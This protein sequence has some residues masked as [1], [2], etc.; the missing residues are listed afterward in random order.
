MNE[1]RQVAL[2]N[3]ELTLLIEALDA[4]CARKRKA[5]A[6]RSSPPTSGAHDQIVRMERLLEYLTKIRYG[7]EGGLTTVSKE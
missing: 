3:G 2:T 1:A 6:S 7:N 5:L 4:S